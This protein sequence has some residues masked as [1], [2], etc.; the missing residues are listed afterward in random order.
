[1]IP[2]P[3]PQVVQPRV[4]YAR[5]YN[6]GFPGLQRL[7]PFDM[8]KYGRAYCA[9]RRELRGLLIDRTL[10]PRSPVSRE[11]L[12]Q[13]H[14][15]QYLDRL[16]GSAYLARA[17]EVAPLARVP[18]W[19]TD[20]LVLRPMRWATAGTILAAREAMSRGLTINLSGGYHHAAPDRGEGFCI[21]NDIAV[22]IAVLRE[23]GMLAPGDR[24]AYVDCDAHQG[25]GVCH[26]FA[27]DRR[28]FIYDQYNRA[29]Y[30]ADPV[31]RRRIDCDVPLSPNTIDHE[32]LGA[33]ESTLPR[34]LDGIARAGPIR[35]AIYNAGT[36]ICRGDPLGAL[37]ITA[38]GVLKRD[39]F[40]L[41]QLVERGI[42]TL[43][44]PSGGYTSESYRLIADSVAHAL[45]T[46]P[47]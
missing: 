2:S 18:A 13:V 1:M 5:Q 3:K 43:M 7:H 33:L 35:F 25:N 12:L 30:P 45:R 34:F 10:R 26:A 14:T 23:S 11:Q 24:V 29:I 19:L 46:W 8:R 4:I 15:P 16:R 9:L 37:S 6:I 21:Y 32:Y 31:A 20:R 40:V 42:S 17:L 47:E 38:A 28:V 41:S 22:A 27:S 44:L 36:D 39:R